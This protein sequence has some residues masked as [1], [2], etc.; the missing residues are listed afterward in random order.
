MLIGD[1]GRWVVRWQKE[2]GQ[3][4][5]RSAI[6]E[7]K[8]DRE[9]EAG[10]K[11]QYANVSYWDLRVRIVRHVLRVSTRDYTRIMYKQEMAVCPQFR[12]KS[13]Y[14]NDDSLAIYS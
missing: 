2:G 12:S 5:N 7:K 8:G 6:Q 9:E 3:E 1:R 4:K 14:L 11:A 10:S 13:R